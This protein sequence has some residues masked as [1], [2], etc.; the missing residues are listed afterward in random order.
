MTDQETTA[1]EGRQEHMHLVFSVTTMT[2][3]VLS[4][5]CA[6][7][8]PLHSS[9][10]QVGEW[11][12]CICKNKKTYY[13]SERAVKTMPPW[14]LR[15]WSEEAC[16]CDNWWCTSREVENHQIPG[17][18]CHTTPLTNTT[19]LAK[20]ANYHLYFICNLISVRAR[21]LLWCTCFTEAPR[22]DE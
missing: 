20:K 3:R 2:D 16:P 22:I 1:S 17:C 14:M 8:P 19:A 6:D 18:T 11:H 12:W 13:K 5:V 10:H 21:A 15:R 4:R 9:L 7:L